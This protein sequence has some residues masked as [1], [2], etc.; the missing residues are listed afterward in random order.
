MKNNAE[1]QGKDGSIGENNFVQLADYWSSTRAK[2][3]EHTRLGQTSGQEGFEAFFFRG[4]KTNS[5]GL[6]SGA[7][8]TLAEKV[9][10]EA[11]KCG[12]VN[13]CRIGF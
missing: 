8:V 10:P 7:Y 4:L 2:A 3:L 5:I 6:Q 12:F 13:L 11:K 9:A 1:Y